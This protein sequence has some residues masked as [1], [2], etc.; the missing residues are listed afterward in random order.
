[1]EETTDLSL[2]KVMLYFVMS[3]ELGLLLKTLQW[4]KYITTIKNRCGVTL[5]CAYA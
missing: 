5:I 1:M 3:Y 4:L 2:T